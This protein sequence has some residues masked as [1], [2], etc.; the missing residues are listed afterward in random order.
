[1]RLHELGVQ[2]SRCV[3]Q[4]FFSSAFLLA[5]ILS[6]NV[7]GGF[8]L[9]VD[10]PY[11]IFN[12]PEKSL[13]GFSVEVHEE[14]KRNW[15]LIGAPDDESPLA[16]S[17][18][19]SRPGSVYRCTSRPPFQC[20]VIPFDNTGN[21]NV[22]GS[23]IDE[24]S[25]QWFGASISSSG[26]DGYVVACAPRYTYFSINKRRR[27]P[28]GTC[29]TSS[30]YF[31]KFSEYA[32][33][34]TDAWGYHSQGYCQAGFSV[35]ASKNRL[36]IGAVGSRYWQ[37]EV[38]SQ[39]IRNRMDL[40][41]T[42]NSLALDDQYM[43][44]SMAVIKI[45]GTKQR[46]AEEYILVGT[47]KGNNLTGEV[48]LLHGRF[49]KDV[50][51]FLGEQ[52]GS[53]FGHSLTVGDFNG[54]GLEDFS[55]GA[56]LFSDKKTSTHESGRVYVI[57]QNENQNFHKWQILDGSEHFGRFGASVASVGDLDLD[58]YDELC[59]GEP[60][61][62]DGRGRVLLFRGSSN[63]VIETPS[64]ILR[65]ANYGAATAAFGFSIR[66]GDKDFDGNGYPDLLIG[67][68]DSNSVIVIKSKQVVHLET[69][70]QFDLGSN[71]IKS[72]DH[73][74]VKGDGVHEGAAEAGGQECL[75]TSGE[76]ATCMDFIA[77]QKYTGIGLSEELEFIVVYNLDT[78]KHSSRLFFLNSPKKS[79]LK[80]PVTLLKGKEYC[81]KRRIFLLPNVSD[82]LTP[83]Q[84]NATHS[85]RRQS[86]SERISMYPSVVDTSKN[87]DVIQ[88]QRNCGN[89]NKCVPDLR[90]QSKTLHNEHIIGSNKNMELQVE[91]SNVGEDAFEAKFKLKLE[92]NLRFV[93]LKEE[94]STWIA[95]TNKEGDTAAIANM[96]CSP[97]D[98]N[99]GWTLE[100]NLGN[101]ML[102]GN[103]RLFTVVLNIHEDTDSAEMRLEMNVSSSNEED[104]DTMDDNLDQHSIRLKSV[105]TLKIRG[106][107]V[108]ET[109]YHNLTDDVDNGRPDLVPSRQHLQKI[110][111]VYQIENA[112]PSEMLKGDV[113][114]L[115]PSFNLDGSPLLQITQQPIVSG[116]GICKNIS[117]IRESQETCGQTI[118]SEIAC[119]IGPLAAKE[120]VL[121]RIESRLHESNIALLSSFNY[122]ISSKV[123][124]TNVQSR[125]PSDEADFASYFLSTKIEVS[126]FQTHFLSRLPPWLLALSILVGVFLVCVLATILYRFG[127]FQR[128]RPYSGG[129]DQWVNGSNGGHVVKPTAAATAPMSTV[130]TTTGVGTGSVRPRSPP[131]LSVPTTS[132]RHRSSYDEYQCV[133]LPGD[134]VL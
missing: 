6:S 48:V 5:C 87:Y 78:R 39:N 66:S 34:R 99:N 92:Q 110:I 11:A 27:E 38:F 107:S 116:S 61:A 122:K 67:S 60:Y 24:K 82:K 81:E 2:C 80:V 132:D 56:P 17:N 100:C 91:V 108:P 113:K 101:P 94:R 121:F 44:Y 133:L 20:S 85:L 10:T 102:A 130:A 15:I 72:G 129:D 131:S 29:Y 3:A 88:I 97:P 76:T 13:F 96:L 77:C 46:Y 104:E 22:S 31:S 69:R 59:V 134:E 25:H 18:S 98:K 50:R 41:A 52:I 64:Q 79:S 95:N 123:K 93:K 47:P 19:L 84:I 89:D 118:C 33:C 115:W 105:T 55:V 109:V 68:P 9:D 30:E 120:F 62:D 111:H 51:R 71:E 43:G 70:I 54:D 106:L 12:G 16:T 114:F 57:Y 36:Y 58:G 45:K 73:A 90:V 112:G 83:L 53:Y 126:N 7:C 75:L 26:I 23:A 65:G 8:N 42:G 74:A 103:K 32:P 117:V 37:G 124:V 86:D 21:N 14:N 4:L 128:K 40:V 35:V 125:H 1:M 49:L 127:F 28:V 119:T 63:G